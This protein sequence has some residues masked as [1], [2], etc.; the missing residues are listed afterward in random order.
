MGSARVPE[1]ITPPRK[2]LPA[3]NS[4]Y[5]VQH[6][7]NV[8]VVS[9]YH[10][11]Q[12][13]TRTHLTQLSNEHVAAA[14]GVSQRAA[15]LAQHALSLQVVKRLLHRPAELNPLRMSGRTCWVWGGLLVIWYGSRRQAAGAADCRMY[16]GVGTWGAGCSVPA[17]GNAAW[18]RSWAAV[19]MNRRNQIRSANFEFCSD[20]L[21][22]CVHVLLGLCWATDIDMA[23]QRHSSHHR[24]RSAAVVRAGHI[25]VVIKRLRLYSWHRGGAG[26]RAHNRRCQ[27]STPDNASHTC[28][29]VV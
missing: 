18:T 27:A 16:V 19:G 1:R 21:C 13:D 5:T 23:H 11:F 4:T 8:L 2:P 15:P 24:E 6:T 29:P 9:L 22:F 14:H 20:G 10:N 7:G 3:P 25:K 12:Y 28:T 26:I 17:R